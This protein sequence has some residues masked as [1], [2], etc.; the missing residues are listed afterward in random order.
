MTAN[1]RATPCLLSLLPRPSTV[2]LLEPHMFAR[3]RPA[4][5]HQTL[6]GLS[7][8][9][10]TGQAAGPRSSRRD[11]REGG[12]LMW[13]KSAGRRVPPPETS[14][15]ATA[16]TTVCDLLSGVVAAFGSSAD[17]GWRPGAAVSPVL[18]RLLHVSAGSAGRRPD[19][20]QRRWRGGRAARC[21]RSG[22]GHLGPAPRP[23]TEHF[24]HGDR[25]S[26]QSSRQL[27]ADA[28]PVVPNGPVNG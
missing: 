7:L 5:K 28:F 3:R 1:L 22:Y 18:R 25:R 8:E 20:G 24:R 6:R 23:A 13:S 15:E 19:A 12:L 10:M 9:L 4:S 11:Q 16:R 2:A 26:S 27:P 21:A 14:P 17:Q